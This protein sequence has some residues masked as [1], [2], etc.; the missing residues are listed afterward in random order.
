MFVRLFFL[1]AF[2]QVFSLQNSFAFDVDKENEAENKNPKRKAKE[3][4]TP[5]S[6]RQKKDKN[7][8]LKLLEDAFSPIRRALAIEKTKGHV[9]R[10]KMKEIY[11]TY[12]SQFLTP[13]MWYDLKILD[14][15]TSVERMSKGLNPLTYRGEETEVHHVTQTPTKQALLPKGLHRSKNRYIV[16]KKDL[17]SGEVT[18]IATRLTRLKAEDIIKESTAKTLKNGENVKFY[19][20]GNVLHPASGPSKIDRVAF[21]KEKHNTL[22]GVAKRLIF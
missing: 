14:P 17:E 18:I 16:T 15:E 7:S 10:K 5:P 6:K 9:S 3:P 19:R 1:V 12:G 20:I 8:P 22:T 2:L 4:S 21:K 11:E 13:E